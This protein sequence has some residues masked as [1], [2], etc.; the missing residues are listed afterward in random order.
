[1]SYNEIKIGERFSKLTVLS[2]LKDKPRYYKC[3]CKCGRMINC[4][5]DHLLNGTAVKCNWCPKKDYSGQTINNFKIIKPVKQ[6]K[7]HNWKYLVKCH[8]GQYFEAFINNIRN[9]HTKDCG[10][11]KNGNLRGEKWRDYRGKYHDLEGLLKVSNKGRLYKIGTNTSKN[12]RGI[13]TGSINS[14][15]YNRIHLSVNGKEYNLASHQL[16]AETWIP[17]PEHKKYVD[18]INAIRDDNRVSNLQ[19]VTS[20]E[21]NQNSNYTNK[22]RK[23]ITTSLS[24]NNWLQKRLKKPCCAEN[25]QGIIIFFPSLEDLK[26]YFGTKGHT[27]SFIKR[28]EFVSNP[29]SKFYGWKLSFTKKR[30]QDY[31]GQIDDPRP[32]LAKAD[33]PQ[34]TK[35]KA[36]NSGTGQV[37]H[38]LSEQDCIQHFYGKN[39]KTGIHDIAGLMKLHRPVKSKRSKFY[40]WQLEKE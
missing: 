17:N 9:G 6:D 23:R 19:W 36:T 31:I 18:H 21:N 12:Q 13:I 15:G 7:N 33:N 29:K 25:K 24:K 22:L 8:C 1:M 37:L 3:Q 30:D 40:G 28:N 27:L 26:D 2:Q 11:L 20:S 32:K 38:F 35:V 16:I 39:N 10:H 4:R 14:F 5:K 34:L